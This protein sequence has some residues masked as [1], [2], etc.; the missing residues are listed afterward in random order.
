MKQRI[1]RYVK[2]ILLTA[3]VVSIVGMGVLFYLGNSIKFNRNY[4]INS[5]YLHNEGPFIVY[6]ADSTVTVNY[7]QGSDSIGYYIKSER[8]D[9]VDDVLVHY[10]PD[11]SAFQVT[12]QPKR[13]FQPPEVT[14]PKPEKILAISDIEG[15]FSSFRKLLINNGVI[16]SQLNWTFGNGHLVLAGDFV[17]RGYF[18]TQVLFLIYKLEQQAESYGGRVHY[19]L[20]NHELMNMQGDHSYA[21]GKYS[22]AASA[23]GLRHYQL[24]DPKTTL[25]GRWMSTRNVIE[26][27]GDY[28]FTHAGLHPDFA[29]AGLSLQA[30]N[31]HVRSRYGW[32]YYPEKEKDKK[33]NYLLFDEEKCLYWYRGYFKGDVSEDEIDSILKAF[34]AKRIIVGHTIQNHIRTL[35]DGRVV[36]VDVQHAQEQW[37]SYFPA[38]TTEALLIENEKFYRVRD[39]GERTELE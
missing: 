33:I 18:V 28:I 13:T 11:S 2:H 12:I 32:V 8:L 19:I 27:I 16:D 37:G 10:Y 30:I 14:Y 24:Y 5:Q 34:G 35:Y 25:L 20:G 38:A 9:S 22:Y 29:T 21:A 17:D 31:D 23:L 3:L 7:L 39:N 36:G 4:S 26:K 15:G 1:L 6:G